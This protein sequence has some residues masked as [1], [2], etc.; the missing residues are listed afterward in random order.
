M[1]KSVG[2]PVD[3]EPVLRTL[4]EG[5]DDDEDVPLEPEPLEEQQSWLMNSDCSEPPPLGSLATWSKASSSDRGASMFASLSYR[6]NRYTLSSVEVWCSCTISD[7]KW[8]E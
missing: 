5:D 1:P 8:P 2:D 7:A 6:A 3:W 4:Q